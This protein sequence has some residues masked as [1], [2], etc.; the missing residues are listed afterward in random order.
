[1]SLTLIGAEAPAT[2]CLPIINSRTESHDWAALGRSRHLDQFR[3]LFRLNSQGGTGLPKREA[4]HA[5]EAHAIGEL[6]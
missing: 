1:V 6:P 3:R 4:C 2:L 5:L